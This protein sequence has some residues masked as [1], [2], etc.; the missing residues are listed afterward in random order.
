MSRK[1][2]RAA[3]DSVG[4]T[5]NSKA[6]KKLSKIKNLL[7]CPVCYGTDIEYYQCENGH[8]VCKNCHKKVSKCPTCRVK[9]TGT[10]ALTLNSLAEA[11]AEPCKYAHNGCAERFAPGKLRHKTRH[12]YCCAE[13]DRKCPHGGCKWKGHKSKYEKHLVDCHGAIVVPHHGVVEWG[14]Y[15]PKRGRTDDVRKIFLFKGFVLDATIVRSGRGRLMKFSVSPCPGVTGSVLTVQ[16]ETPMTFA[17]NDCWPCN[18]LE[19]PTRFDP[20]HLSTMDIE[21]APCNSVEICFEGDS[22]DFLIQANLGVKLGDI[23]DYLEEKHKIKITAMRRRGGVISADQT[24]LPGE[25]CFF[26][27]FES[28]PA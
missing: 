5:P 9:M 18:G 6:E 16:G 13:Q 19:Y 15:A 26:S 12:E 27:I 2:N 11:L 7:E 24:V 28:R 20:L 4:G 8:T 1:R 3:V 17:A 22:I 14:K 23:V 25:Q 21:E 10:R